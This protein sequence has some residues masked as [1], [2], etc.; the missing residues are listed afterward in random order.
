M[1]LEPNKEY[2]SA[3]PMYSALNQDTFL[4]LCVIIF[5]IIG[6]LYCLLIT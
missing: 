2:S 4:S 6:L 5:A 3:T 1:N